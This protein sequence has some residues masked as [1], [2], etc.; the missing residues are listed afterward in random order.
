[1]RGPG[2]RS[3]GGW[4]MAKE[5]WLVGLL[6]SPVPPAE[7]VSGDPRQA[8]GLGLSPRTGS[9]LG[10]PDLNAGVQGDVARA[11]GSV[12]GELGAGLTWGWRGEVRARRS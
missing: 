12:Q 7:D 10:G 11:G 1:M 2:L 8:A 9:A 4:D 3:S 5:L 6:H